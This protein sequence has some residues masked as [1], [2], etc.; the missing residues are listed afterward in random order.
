MTS[1]HAPPERIGTQYRHE[2]L[3]YSGLGEFL[4]QTTAFIRGAVARHEPVLVAVSQRK[5]DLL[6]KC[7]GA[8]ADWVEF[9]DIAE[10][11]AN[12]GRIIA[13]WQQFVAAHAGSA[14]LWGVGEPVCPERS[15]VELA[16]CQLHEAL[17]NVAFEA[18]TPFWLL[19]PYDLEALDADVIDEAQRTHPFVADGE[20]GREN[21]AFRPIDV[22]DPFD[23]PVPP[24]PAATASF[25]FRSNDLGRLRAFVAEQAHRAGLDEMQAEALILAA[26]EIATNSVRHGGGRGEVHTW[27]DGDCLVCEVSDSGHIRSPLVGRLRPPPDAAGGGGLWVANQLCDLIQIYSSARGTVVRAWIYAGQSRA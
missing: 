23:R 14:Q 18:H 10:V 13:A 16:E 15:P 21:S 6:R 1:P 26:N 19:C 11:G 20:G 24:R 9:A 8:D 25:S 4:D 2:A 27:S 5:I 22:A 12:P 3:L 7:L 17:L